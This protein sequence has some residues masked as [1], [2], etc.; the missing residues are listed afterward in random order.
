MS[1]E[2]FMSQLERLL[3]DVSEEEKREALEYYRGYFEDAG[4]EN[5]ERILRELESPEKVAQ[6]IKVDLGMETG[7]VNSEY[8]ETGYQDNRFVNTQELDKYQKTDNQTENN[9]Q[10]QYQGQSAST[11]DENR[12]LKIILIVVV[13]VFTS[14]IWLGIGGGILGTIFGLAVAAV[15]VTGAFYITGAVLFGI[16]IGEL[17][18]S[19]LAVG[20]ALMG[21]GC[22][23]LSLAI[24]AT[25]ACVWICGKF[26]PWA[27]NGIVKL[28]RSLFSRKEGMA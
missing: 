4:I 11:Y 9:G 10:N 8:T 28:C 26:V 20:F 23:V 2:E 21:A 27:W 3:T 22:L 14:P 6:T 7:A 19:E 17:A 5:E 16:G 25:L 12:T 18:V 24:L 1:R 13:A 15:A